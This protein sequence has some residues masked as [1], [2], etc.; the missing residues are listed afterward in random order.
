VPGIRSLGGIRSPLQTP[1]L[2]SDG[3]C[4]NRTGIERETQVLRFV[5]DCLSVFGKKTE[6]EKTSDEYAAWR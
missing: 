3:T 4:G 5:L 6:N 2:T 1:M